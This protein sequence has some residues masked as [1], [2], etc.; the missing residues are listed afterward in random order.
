MEYNAS[1]EL[2]MLVLRLSD[3]R[4]QLIARENIE[5]PQ[6]AKPRQIAKV[7]I[8]G[9]GTGLHWPELDLDLYVPSLLRNIYGTNRWMVRL[10]R[11]G[12]TVKSPEKR[13]APESNGREGG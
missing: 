6:G 1:P 3:G 2:D 11:R 8:R 4:R 10:G 13:K 9:S 5:G 7:E 12:G